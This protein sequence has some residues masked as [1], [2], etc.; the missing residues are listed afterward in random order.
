MDP[1]RL[2]QSVAR[3]AR[4]RLT[5]RAAL[6]SSGAG[7][8]SALLDRSGPERECRGRPRRHSR[9]GR[10]AGDNLPPDVPAWMRTPG[11]PASPYGERAP[12]EESVVRSR[13]TRTSASPPWPTCTARSRP[14]RSSTRSTTGASRPST[15][16]STGLL[17][18]GLVERPTLFTMDDLKRF[19]AVSVVHF[20]ECSGNSFSEWTEASMS[21]TV[22]LSH[23]WTS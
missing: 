14:M 3:V 19:P 15:R 2:G 17:V 6:A 20:L 9:G 18:H 11:A 5:R 8:A 7:L 21:P 1:L 12:A 10:H 23:G 22:Q 4:A 16:A 13:P